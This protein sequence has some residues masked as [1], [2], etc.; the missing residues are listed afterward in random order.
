VLGSRKTRYKV[1]IGMKKKNRT[2]L[3]VLFALF[4]FIA[5]LG[6]IQIS[7][8]SANT[9]PS[10]VLGTAGNFAILAKTGIS[11]TGT[12]SIT[13]NIG[14]SPAA[15][16]YITG[17][18]LIMDTSNTFS[19]S[20]L[21]IGKVYA[22]NY[23]TPTPTMM[24][25]AIS[26]MQTA[27]T[28]VAGLTTPAPVTA[29]GAGNIGG[30]TITAG[31]YKWSTNVIIPSAVTLSGSSSDE[32]VF[33][34]AGTLTV[35]SNVQVILSG[36]AQASNIFWVIAGQTTLGTHSAFNGIILDKTAIALTTGATLNGIALAQTAVTLQSN[37]I[38]QSNNIITTPTSSPTITPTPPPTST[39]TSTPI[40][41][42]TPKSTSTPIPTSTPKSTSTKPNYTAVYVAII[43]VVIIAAVA[44][45]AVVLRRRKIN[46]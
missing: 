18:G 31:I 38:T 44:V 7:N 39:S 3:S 5:L 32:W 19:T 4:C 6:I 41:T 13:G 1:V 28:T 30:L 36:G 11:T 43:A 17:F 12:T 34:I 8:V 25:T 26:D 21:V 2:R 9:L 22:A 20:S 14:V 23:A 33:Q 15:A 45:A 42:S 16:T 40:P 35:S 46:T 10:N 27:Y 29:L 24:T 37:T